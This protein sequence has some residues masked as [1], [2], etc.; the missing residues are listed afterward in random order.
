MVPVPSDVDPG[1]LTPAH[2]RGSIELAPGVW[3]ARSVVE[4]RAARS[5]GPGG[6]NVNKVNTRS[7]LRIAID[8]IPIP[9]AARARLARLGGR[10]VTEDGLLVIAAEEHR[11]QVRNKAEALERLRE[12]IVRALVKPRP[13]VPTKPTKGSERRRVEG[14]MLRGEAKKRRRPPGSASEFD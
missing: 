5:S 4:F 14:K 10:R 6:Q 3:V 12:L 11:S 13:R 8:D 2:G 1:D 7:E 9:G